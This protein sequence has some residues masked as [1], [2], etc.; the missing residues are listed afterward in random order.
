[1][2]TKLMV[3]CGLVLSG[4]CVPAIALRFVY[5]SGNTLYDALQAKDGS[6]LRGYAIGYIVGISDA[7]EGSIT[8]PGYRFCLPSKVNSFLL[9]DVV[10]KSL[11]D[12]PQDR[13]LGAL[14]LTARALGRAFPCPS[15]PLATTPD[16]TKK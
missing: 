3:L 2:C 16:A 5:E 15:Y 6:E 11:A 8:E 12:N 14:F 7:V 4:L 10:A 9:V 1:M 13:Q